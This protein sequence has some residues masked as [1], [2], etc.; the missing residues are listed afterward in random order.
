MSPA[1][2]S[3]QPSPP[4][5][6][7]PNLRW[8]FYKIRSLAQRSR[9]VGP[10]AF[11]LFGRAFVLLSA[12]RL[13]LRVVPVA[14]IIAWKQRPLSHPADPATPAAAELRARIRHAILVVA[15]YAP[16]RFVCFP[17]CL[18]AAALLRSAGLESRLHYGISRDASGKL[19]THTWLESGNEILIGGEDAPRYSTLAIY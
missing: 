18:A 16:T 7:P 3:P 15:R 19:N 2:S 10:S 11:V 1:G 12:A 4:A 9:Q 5:P 14:R 13:A 8:R 17:Q 6:P